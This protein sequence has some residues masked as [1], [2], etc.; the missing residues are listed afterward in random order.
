MNT[1]VEEDKARVSD[2]TYVGIVVCLP[3]ISLITVS[4]VIEGRNIVLGAQSVYWEKSG[5]FIG[6]VSA[7]MLKSAGYRYVVIGHCERRAYFH[8]MDET[9]NKR[10]FSALE[11]RLKRIL[12][13][14]ET[15][16]EQKNETLN[17]VKRQIVNGLKGL[18]ARQMASGVVA[19]GPVWP[20]GTGK[21]ATSGQAQE[22]YAFI[23]KDRK[24]RMKQVNF[25]FLWQKILL[26]STLLRGKQKTRKVCQK[27]IDFDP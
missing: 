1:V 14:G 15:L 2:V 17:V 10:I 19:F 26:I 6:E 3:F 13:V 16:S 23:R 8:E 11:E 24:I 21:T 9:V 25:S 4:D 7:P 20:I 18:S 22:V 5:A 12:C 27:N